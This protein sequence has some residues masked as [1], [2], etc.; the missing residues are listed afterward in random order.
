[1][2]APAVA[3]EFFELIQFVISVC[4]LRRIASLD[5]HFQLLLEQ[6]LIVDMDLVYVLPFL[7]MYYFCTKSYK[8]AEVV[9]ISHS[10]GRLI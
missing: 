3:S 10:C 2:G 8:L 4:I 9:P 6:L 7:F 1:M 5:L